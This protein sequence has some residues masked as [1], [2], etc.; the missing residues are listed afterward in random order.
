M[1]S[2]A[3]DDLPRTTW[4]GICDEISARAIIRAEYYVCW[5]LLQICKERKYRIKTLHTQDIA[6]YSISPLNENDRSMRNSRLVVNQAILTHSIYT[7]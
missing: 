4:D 1:I 3:L 6:K 5:D 2:R 7:S